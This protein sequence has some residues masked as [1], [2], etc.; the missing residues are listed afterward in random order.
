MVKQNTPKGLTRRQQARHEK[1]QNAQRTITWIAIAVVV[2]VVAL[3]AIALGG[4]ALQSQKKMATIDNAAIT[5]GDFQRRQ[6]YE[7]TLLRFQIYKYQS[8]LDNLQAEGG[9]GLESLIQQYQIYLSSL[10]QQ[11]STDNAELF[12]K[13]VLD[14]MVEEELIRKEAATRGIAVSEQEIDIQIEKTMGYD[15]EAASAAVTETTTTTGTT[16]TTLEE[17]QTAY[18]NFK[19]N[20]LTGSISEA[21]YR[22]IVKA[23]LLQAQ[24]QDA[25]SENVQTTEDQVEAVVLITG[26]A[27]SALVFQTR[28]NSGE[29]TT[30]T[31]I[32]ELNSDAATASA[33][34]SL[35]WLPLGYLGGQVG[36]DVEQVAFNTP[37]GRASEPVMGLDGNYYVIY[38]TGHEERELSDDLLED[39]RQEQ[40]NS[41]VETQKESRVEYFDW[42]EAIVAD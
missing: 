7:R 16:Q 22:D 12:G 10:E 36:P 25:I 42:Q 33:G 19:T 4:V 8:D 17:F 30:E 1:E 31:L 9:E 21:E 35:P 32:T 14:S 2:I 18:Q 28:L 6:K 27:E 5:A 38:V 37:V 20:I 3:S 13:G 11:L 15:R 29:A 39:A 24:V 26:T 23:G 40:Y 34:Y 41:W